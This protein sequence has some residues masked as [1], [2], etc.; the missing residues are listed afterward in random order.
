MGHALNNN[1]IKIVGCVFT[2][3]LVVL[4]FFVVGAM[5]RAVVLKQILWPQKQE[6]RDEGGWKTEA[7][8]ASGTCGDISAKREHVGTPPMGA[9]GHSGESELAR[10]FRP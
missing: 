8:V 7:E 2:C 6:D 10:R 9:P 3:I 1:P 5:L 4:W